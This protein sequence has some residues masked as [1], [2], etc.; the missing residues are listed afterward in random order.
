MTLKYQRLK[1]ITQ[2]VG[3]DLLGISSAHKIEDVKPYFEHWIS[4]GA[5]ATMGWAERHLEMRLDPTIL[6]DGCRSVIVLGLS[7]LRNGDYSDHSMH[8]SGIDYHYLIKDMLR[9]VEELLKEEDP[10][11]NIKIC[12]DSAPILEKYWAVESGLG[13]IGRN[14]LVINKKF[15]SF[16]LLGEILIDREFDKYDVK[17]DFN[18]CGECHKCIDSCPG[19]AL[20]MGAHDARGC[21]SYL[22]IEHKGEFTNSQREIIKRGGSY[23]GCEI[24][25]RV[26][27]WN[28]KAKKEIIEEKSNFTTK[29]FKEDNFVFDRDKFLKMSSSEFKRGYKSTSLYRTSLKNI[30]RNIDSLI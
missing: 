4:S 25:Q 18:G 26:C 11:I 17:D 6:M 27:P 24:C 19:E 20:K 21:I 23:F 30:I 3:F 10:D 5:N 16:F 2:E 8:A 7:Y 22:T 28:I 14:S 15:G 29:L 12:V 1:K 9:K 13:W